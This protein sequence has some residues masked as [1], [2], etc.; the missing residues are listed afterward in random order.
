MS[1]VPIKPPLEYYRSAWT[2]HEESVKIPE[3]GTA[4]TR[5][6]PKLLFDALEFAM[7]FYSDLHVHTE[8]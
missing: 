2:L 6:F 3:T 7:F 8:C 5:R 1:S 4:L